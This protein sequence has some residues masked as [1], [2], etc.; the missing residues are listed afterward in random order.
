VVSHRSAA[1]LYG[2]G[3]LPADRHEFTV[4]TRRQSRREDVRF[5]VR[6]HGP[7][8]WIEHG[9]LPVTR[10]SRIASDLLLDSEDPEAVAQIVADSIRE[11]YDYPGT[12]AAA[13]APHAGR[14]GLRRGDGLALLRWLLDLVGDR[15]TERWMQEARQSMDPQQLEKD[16][17]SSAPGLK[18]PPRVHRVDSRS[19]SF[20]LA[21][22]L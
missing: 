21:S 13:L 8:K 5:Y 9:G 4:P 1:S 6:P 14:F 22:V 7:G 12:F 18:G 10:P 3:H 20:P 2:V 11:V 16:G 15:E 19:P 17:W